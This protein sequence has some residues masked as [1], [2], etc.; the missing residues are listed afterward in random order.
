MDKSTVK[1]F[2]RE[3]RPVWFFGRRT[4]MPIK[5][6]IVK[7]CE[8]SSREYAKVDYIYDDTSGCGS[9]KIPLDFLYESREELI[10]GICNEILEER[11]EIKA[12]VQTKDDCI[13]FMFLHTVS[14]AGEHTDWTARCT[15]QKIAK[16]KWGIDLELAD[17]TGGTKIPITGNSI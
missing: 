1:K 4:Y 9:D 17:T 14:C 10:A 5:A 6:R 2:Q 15:I 7:I 16:N 8:D 13:R 11:E 12:A 3:N